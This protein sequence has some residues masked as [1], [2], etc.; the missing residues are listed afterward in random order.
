MLAQM[1]KQRASQTQQQRT[2]R[3]WTEIIGDDFRSI[4]QDAGQDMHQTADGETIRHFG[5]TGTAD[6]LRIDI[7]NYAWRTAESSE[8][9]TVF[10]EFNPTIGLVRTE[11]DYAA[12]ASVAENVQNAPEIISGQFRYYDGGTWHEHWA[13]LD[14][15]SVPSAIEITFYSLPISAANRWRRGETGIEEPFLS[16]VLEQ[17]PSAFQGFEE[18]H[19]ARPPQPLESSQPPPMPYEPLPSS[20][21]PNPFHSLFGDD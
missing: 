9:R 18:Y 6:Q 11:R 1:E 7:S 13:S 3:H 12:E 19:R 5:V 15:K 8:L 20:S 21:P 4:I 2:I 10:Y 17:I 14:R 16:R